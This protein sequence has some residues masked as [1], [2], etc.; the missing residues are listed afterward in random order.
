MQDAWMCL[1][2]PLTSKVMKQ[3]QLQ[4]HIPL[5]SRQAWLHKN[6]PFSLGTIFTSINIHSRGNQ[7]SLLYMPSSVN[8]KSFPGPLKFTKT[9]RFSARH[10]KAGL[11]HCSTAGPGM[12]SVG[13]QPP[14]VLPSNHSYKGPGPTNVIS[15]FRFANWYLPSYVHPLNNPRSTEWRFLN[16]AVVTPQKQASKVTNS[17]ITDASTFVPIVMIIY[18]YTPVNL[19]VK[20]SITQLVVLLCSWSTGID[21]IKLHHLMSSCFHVSAASCLVPSFCTTLCATSSQ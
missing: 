20:A 5:E 21:P 4:K 14:L 12:I 16:L 3:L 17:D 2:Q 19:C 9:D 6:Q 15:G 1:K 8:V 18:V 13:Q 11:T 7:A 10:Q